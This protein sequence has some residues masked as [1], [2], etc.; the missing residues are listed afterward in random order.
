[1]RLAFGRPTLPGSDFDGAVRQALEQL[2]VAGLVLVFG[3]KGLDCFVAL[4]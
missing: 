4:S 3:Q 2:A 1:M